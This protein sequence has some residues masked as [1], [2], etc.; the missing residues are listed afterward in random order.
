MISRALQFKN[1]KGGTLGL[2]NAAQNIGGIASL[3]FQAMIT[4]GLGRR[5]AIA[6]GSLI[7]L[8]GIAMQTASNTIGVFSAFL[9]PL[10]GSSLALLLTWPA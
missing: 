5:K 2:F 8:G 4:D 3:P 10:H 7:M 6:L 1:P 9:F